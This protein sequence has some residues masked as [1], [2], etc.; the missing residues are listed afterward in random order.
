MSVITP[1]KKRLYA[2]LD[3]YGTELDEAVAESST[4]KQQQMFAAGYSSYLLGH[5]HEPSGWYGDVELPP[6]VTWDIKDSTRQIF[7]RCGF[8]YLLGGKVTA[9][10]AERVAFGM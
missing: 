4:R 5:R 8:A 7:E 6:V 10:A 9:S 3:R 1:K 2:A